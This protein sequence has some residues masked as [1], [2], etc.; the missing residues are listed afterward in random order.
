MPLDK[1]KTYYE[2]S[3]TAF[4]L[5]PQN[6]TNQLILPIKLF[7]YAAFGLPVI[8]SNFGHIHEIIQ[9]GGIGKS[10]NPHNAKEAAAAWIDLIAADTYKE[11][12]PAC[13]H[14]VKTN[15]LWENQKANLL[16]IYDE[17]TNKKVSADSF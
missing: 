17:L 10:V 7:E 11:Y 12:V 1:V 14:C 15:Y 3:K 2:K 5:F 13:V 6:R 16:R 4:C 8:G 9:S